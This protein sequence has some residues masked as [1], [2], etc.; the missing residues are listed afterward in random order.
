MITYIQKH[1]RRSKGGGASPHQVWS[2]LLYLF[3]KSKLSGG[4]SPPRSITAPTPLSKSTKDH[5]NINRPDEISSTTLFL[6][7]TLIYDRA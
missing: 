7:V 5:S 2:I 3:I 4:L 1:R 6:C